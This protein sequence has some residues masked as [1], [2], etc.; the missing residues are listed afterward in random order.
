MKE[1]EIIL[2]IEQ[3]GYVPEYSLVRRA[4]AGG[5]QY[6]FRV[7]G[8]TTAP[9]SRGDTITSAV[10]SYLLDLPSKQTAGVKND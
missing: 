2:K 4:M 6:F 10:E 7:L 1:H 9:E 8:V 5:F 3:K